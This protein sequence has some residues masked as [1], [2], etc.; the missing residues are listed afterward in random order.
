MSHRVAINQSISSENMDN[1]K[2]Y[3]EPSKVYESTEGKSMDDYSLSR[4]QR[5]VY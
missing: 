4:Y 3:G 2:A 5:C 1:E